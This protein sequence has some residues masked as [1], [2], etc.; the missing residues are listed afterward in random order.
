MADNRAFYNEIL[1]DHNMHPGHKHDLPDADVEMRG[2]N[3][4]CG[5]EITIELQIDRDKV[6][7]YGLTAIA[8]AVYAF[9]GVVN[10]PYALLMM[11]AATAGGYVGARVARRIPA[12]WLRGG[13]VLTGLVMTALFF[14]RQLAGA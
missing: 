14:W 12:P 10:W 13:I 2:Y 4:S 3:P 8:V 7:A 6:R 5:D 1:I 11:V 9:G